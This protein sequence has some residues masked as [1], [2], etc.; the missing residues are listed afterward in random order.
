MNQIIIFIFS[1]LL[2]NSTLYSKT[3]IINE[4]NRMIIKYPEENKYTQLK[5]VGLI[6]ISHLNNT[7]I[8]Y[9]SGTLIGKN[10]VLTAAHCFYDPE[11]NELSNGKVIFTLQSSGDHLPFGIEIAKK[12]YIP[13]S[14]FKNVI[15][16]R[17]MISK[18]QME[19]DFAFLIL[20]NNIGEEHGWHG[21][22]YNHEDD[23]P[24][25]FFVSL[26]SY[27]FSKNKK[28]TFEKCSVYNETLYGN[29]G[30]FS[31][32]CDIEKGSSG[33]SVINK[34]NKVIGVVSGM[35]KYS[36]FA[37]RFSSES[38]NL[39]RNWIKGIV[40]ENSTYSVDLFQNNNY[41]LTF[42]NKCDKTISFAYRVEKKDN[43]NTDGLFILKQNEKMTIKN[44][45][46]SKYYYYGKLYKN[47][48]QGEWKGKYKFL[49]S[50]YNKKYPFE[51]QFITNEDDR[52][53]S[54]HTH[55]FRCD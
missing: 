18:E 52:I 51:R 32:N 36:N 9:C 54:S 19:N 17:G 48:I 16:M 1:F 30:Y 47:K 53:T 26:L 10:I 37:Y 46:N 8:S 21:L 33:A 44:I 6:S 39:I 23:A 45:I 3:G 50:D 14:F 20:N 38:F 42:I 49:L 41:Q 11:K 34:D 7:V 12:Y 24:E 28:M 2:I 29:S 40:E 25:E 5:K 43:W 55:Y 31:M 4:D 35:G 22:S 15:E 27:P 13:N